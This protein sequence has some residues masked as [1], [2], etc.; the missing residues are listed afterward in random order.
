[1]RL[2]GRGGADPDPKAVRQPETEVGPVAAA[3]RAGL[4]GATDPT[5]TT[6]RS[7]SSRR[8]DSDQSLRLHRS[9][10]PEWLNVCSPQ[11]QRTGRFRSSPSGLRSTAV[12]TRLVR[13]RRRVAT[14]TSR[15]TQQ[16]RPPPAPRN[17][18]VVPTGAPPVPAP[19]QRAPATANDASRLRFLP[20][21]E[22]VPTFQRVEVPVAS[23][24]SGYPV[25]R[26]QMGQ[27]I[28]PRG[29]VAAGTTTTQQRPHCVSPRC[30]T[31][32]TR[33]PRSSS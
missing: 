8:T 18:R 16:P 29:R 25:L 4:S 1:M 9:H 32:Q 30:S 6:D 14:R 27:Q 10:R 17:R 5:S 33:N 21:Q 3:G 26:V 19:P 12:T 28:A 2:R 20:V 22:R 31:G 7:A 13:G 23:K 15:R 11:R 24:P